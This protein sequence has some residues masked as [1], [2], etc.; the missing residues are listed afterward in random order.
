MCSCV[1]SGG[2]VPGNRSPRGTRNYRRLDTSS[3]SYELY[4]MMHGIRITGQGGEGIA[5][6]EIQVSIMSLP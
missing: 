2:N 5:D 4:P 6:K 3:P 1:D